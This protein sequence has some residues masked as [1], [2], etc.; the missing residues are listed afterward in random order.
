MRCTDDTTGACASLIF[1]IF[2]FTFAV[3]CVKFFRDP[4]PPD[5][6]KPRFSWTID[7]SGAIPMV[8]PVVL[9]LSLLRASSR[10]FESS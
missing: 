4:L 5:K 3:Y 2:F 1:F 7:F 6:V 8:K 9:V 10:S